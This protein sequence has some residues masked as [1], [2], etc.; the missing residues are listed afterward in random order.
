MLFMRRTCLF[1]LPLLAVLIGCGQA[2]T[3]GGK[4]RPKRYTKIVSLSPSTTE[5]LAGNGIPLVGRTSAC[6]YPESVKRVPVVGSVEPD[7]EALAR[8]K[9]DLVV[10]DKALYGEAKVRKIE[11]LGAKTYDPQTFVKFQ[12]Q[13]Y[14]LGSL[15]AT[16]TTLA[17]YVDRVRN[18]A[19]AASGSGEGISLAIILPSKN[20]RPL[21][22]GTKGFLGE[23]VRATGAKMIGPNGD[24]FVP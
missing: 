13:C 5:I 2:Q 12:Q 1:L 20:G 15:T 16:E 21:I 17:S 6:N 8:I 14:E 18:A 22:A 9:P 23:I 10:Y 7:Y 19:A 11:A 3:L 4:D 24:N